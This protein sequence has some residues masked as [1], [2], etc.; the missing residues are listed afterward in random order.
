MKDRSEL[1]TILQ[2]FYKEIQTRVGYTIRI[3]N[4]DNAK[5]YF[6]APSKSFMASHDMVY[7]STCPH[8]SQ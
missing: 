4:S 3:L 7:E 1:F 8:I 6:S 2:N 5:E